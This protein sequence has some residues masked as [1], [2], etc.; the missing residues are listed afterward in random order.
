MDEKSIEVHMHEERVIIP[1]PEFSKKA[2]IKS[3]AE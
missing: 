2:H 3:M 1:D